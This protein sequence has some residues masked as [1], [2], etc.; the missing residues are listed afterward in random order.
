MERES[1]LR[2]S[3]ADR[4]TAARR[5][6]VALADGAL[7]I[8]EFDERL[9]AAYEAKT[10]AEL[11]RLTGDLPA[12]APDT[13]DVP[14][15][16]RVTAEPGMPARLR[17]PG[18]P[19]AASTWVRVLWACWLGV[20]TINLVIWV[21]VCFSQMDLVYFWPMWVGGPTAGALVGLTALDKVIRTRS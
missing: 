6:R 13:V 20:V 10:H 15:F 1:Q 18:T 19:V 4:E 2:A 11:A 5:L 17:L 7:E 16:G 9:R 3:N 12:P 14:D 21:L 8:D